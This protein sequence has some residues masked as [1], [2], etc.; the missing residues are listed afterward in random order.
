MSSMKNTK[1]WLLGEGGIDLKSTILIR[2]MV[3]AVF[4]SEGIQKFLYPATRGAGRFEK[5]GLANPELLGSVGT[6][7]DS[8]ADRCPLL[9]F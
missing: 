2:M 4:L 6:P 1:S 7:S 3:G 8:V 9:Y 5:I